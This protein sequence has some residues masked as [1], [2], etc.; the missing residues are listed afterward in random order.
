MRS[1]KPAKNFECE[2]VSDNLLVC[3]LE[4]GE[5]RFVNNG[6]NRWNVEVSY[7]VMP[8]YGTYIGP[9]ASLNDAGYRM[10]H[11]VIPKRLAAL[12]VRNGILA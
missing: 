2:Q 8:G 7:E 4:G 5:V 6:K 9:F 12:L 10:T 3:S 1:L 11:G